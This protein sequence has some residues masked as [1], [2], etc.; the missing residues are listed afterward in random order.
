MSSMP[1]HCLRL[2]L[3]LQLW[4]L[5]SDAPVSVFKHDDEVFTIKWSPAPPAEGQGQL[6][7][8][9]SQDRTVRLYDS[10]SGR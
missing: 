10:Q 8:A 4:R 7:A 5:S 2:C 9:A 1:A 6:L 3:C